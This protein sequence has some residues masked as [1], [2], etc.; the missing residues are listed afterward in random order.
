MEVYLG[1][2][3]LLI[4][5]CFYQL[6]FIVM[7]VGF[8]GRV[9]FSVEVDV[10]LVSGCVFQGCVQLGSVGYVVGFFGVIVELFEDIR[11]RGWLGKDMVFERG[12]S[13]F[14]FLL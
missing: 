5:L 4:Y 6:D 7:F 8:Y 9:I 3:G 2:V 11:V 10:I 12:G 14:F 13:F 1:S